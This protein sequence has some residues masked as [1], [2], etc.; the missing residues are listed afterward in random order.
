MRE[1]GSSLSSIGLTPTQQMK[2]TGV[3]Y[4]MCGVGEASERMLKSETDEQKSFH[5]SAFTKFC[6]YAIRSA[7]YSNFKRTRTEK[8]FTGQATFQ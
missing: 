5:F 3:T 6:T 1:W 4:Y 2:L 8:L 7:V